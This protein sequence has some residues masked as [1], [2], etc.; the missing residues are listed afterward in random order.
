MPSYSKLSKSRLNTC[1]E[2]LQ[3]IFNIVIL[4]F[5]N[6]ILRGH[7]NKTKQTEVFKA[8]K[9]QVEWPNSKHNKSPSMAVDAVPYPVNYKDRERF[10]YF[11][12]Y[13]MGVADMLC[14]EG[15]IKHG[16]RWGGD[17]D[18]DTEVKDNSFDDLAHLELVEK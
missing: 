7:R 17:W 15:V 1:H 8:G 12:G 9:S 6:S 18:D 3:K 14:N 4:Q 2:D 10:V 11:A 13:V 16:L 5:D